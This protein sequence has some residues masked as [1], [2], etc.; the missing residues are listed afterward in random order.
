MAFFL[1]VESSV[2]VF[3]VVLN[4]SMVV[5]H[6]ELYYCLTRVLGVCV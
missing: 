1:V 5:F 6:T 4:A 2:D 3:K